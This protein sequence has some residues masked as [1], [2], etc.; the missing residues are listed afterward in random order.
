MLFHVSSPTLMRTDLVASAY[1]D[2]HEEDEVDEEGLEARSGGNN[3]PATGREEDDEAVANVAPRT[4]TL[5]FASLSPPPAAGGGGSGGGLGCA[6]ANAT[7][8]CQPGPR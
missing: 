6:C 8:R 5:K 2:L 7:V 1:P 4:W 3:A